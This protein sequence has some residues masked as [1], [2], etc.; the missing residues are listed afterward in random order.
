MPQEKSVGAIVFRRENGKTYF[1]LLHY[2]SG[3][4]EFPKG[5]VEKGETEEQ[6][7]RRETKEETGIV[8]LKIMP[9]FRQMIKYFFRSNYHLPKG[10]K[11]KAPW[12]FKMVIFYLAETKTSRIQLSHEHKGYKWLE[13]D[14]AIKKV[15][16]KNSKLLLQNAND[17]IS[18]KSIQNSQKYS[19]GPNL[20]IQ[21]GGP[22]SRP[23]K[24]LPSRREY[25]K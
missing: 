23:A 15:T 11:D 4:W 22:A 9:G 20:N 7:L 6:T 5:H 18:G 21:K 12:I 13:F 19:Q 14:D 1:L 24:S 16:F 25:P 10:Q 17:F 3:H 8:D 2:E